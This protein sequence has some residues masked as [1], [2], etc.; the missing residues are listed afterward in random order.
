MAQALVRREE[1]SRARQEGRE[2]LPLLLRGRHAVARRRQA[3]VAASNAARGP[4][5]PSRRGGA[6]DASGVSGPRPGAV[7]DEAARARRYPLP[8]SR[9]SGKE[10]GPESVLPHV[11][12]P[13]M[14]DFDFEEMMPSDV[15]FENVSSADDLNI[16]DLCFDEVPD[17]FEDLDFTEVQETKRD[18]S[19]NV[20]DAAAAGAR[21][22]T[23][24]R[25]QDAPTR[26]VQTSRQTATP[27]R[28][29]RI[30]AA[31]ATPP[32]P[33]TIRIPAR[34]PARRRRRRR[35]SR[36][37]KTPP[38]PWSASSR[39]RRGRPRETR[40]RRPR[41]SSVRTLEIRRNVAETF[42]SAPAPRC[43]QRKTHLDD[44]A[45]PRPRNPPR[46]NFPTARKRFDETWKP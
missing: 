1:G 41:G 29:R 23:D 37:F 45:G 21:A 26:P 10:G 12:P 15:A 5:F 18:P 19:E 46:S 27:P 2:K 39:R 11:P 20:W 40:R 33:R 22:R 6:A 36:R 31:A 3:K 43:A 32:R 30:H 28:P 24:R 8:R 14:A 35:P 38:T 44:R 4:S 17:Q 25:L 7:A 9:V 16:E 34:R 42:R 13:S